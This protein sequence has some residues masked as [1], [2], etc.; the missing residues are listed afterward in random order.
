VPTLPTTTGQVE[1]NAARG[2]WIPHTSQ[3]PFGGGNHPKNQNRR[4]LSA[5]YTYVYT[6][7]VSALRKQKF[8]PEEKAVPL[9]YFEW[10]RIIVDE[11]HESLCTS[12]AEM[13]VAKEEFEKG[14]TSKGFFTERNRRAGRELLGITEKDI[15]RRPLRCRKAIFGLTVC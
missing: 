6:N 11:I 1:H 3:D 5:R 2:V 8:S 10:E 4:N 12:K 9:E 15:S 13:K 7:S 14:G